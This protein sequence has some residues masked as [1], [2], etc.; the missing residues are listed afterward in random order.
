MPRRHHKKKFDSA[1]EIALLRGLNC[2]QNCF[3]CGMGD[4]NHVVMNFGT[5]V[6][7]RCAGILKELNYT[8]RGPEGVYVRKEIKLIGR[9]GNERAR[10]IWMGNFRANQDSLPNPQKNEEVRN[11]IIDKYNNKKYFLQEMEDELRKEEE[12]AKE[13]ESEEEEDEKDSIDENGTKENMEHKNMNSGKNEKIVENKTND[14]NMG[15]DILCGNENPIN[16]SE[17][18]NKKE[19]TSTLCGNIFEQSKEDSVIDTCTHNNN[20][21][22]D[23]PAMNINH[24]E[25]QRVNPNNTFPFDIINKGEEENEPQTEQN[26]FA[27]PI[28]KILSQSK[29]MTV[30]ERALNEPSSIQPEIIK[31]EKEK[32][33]V[34]KMNQDDFINHLR[35]AAQDRPDYMEMMNDQNNQDLLYQALMNM[36]NPNSVNENTEEFNPLDFLSNFHQ[37]RNKKENEPIVN[38]T[39]NQSKEVEVEPEIKEKPKDDTNPFDDGISSENNSMFQTQASIPFNRNINNTSQIQK[40]QNDILNQSDEPSIIKPCEQQSE[41]KIDSEQPSEFEINTDWPPQKKDPEINQ[42]K[43]DSIIN[44]D[45]PPKA[46]DESNSQINQSSISKVEPMTTPNMDIDVDTSIPPKMNTEENATI[47]DE[48]IKTEPSKNINQI[49]EYNPYN[50]L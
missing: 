39:T 13:E 28:E 34:H 10:K 42:S 44:T 6:C 19:N 15:L 29:P 8:V 23:K 21:T 47:V 26:S 17:I 14:S 18:S 25:R 37:N 38:N 41:M 3:D 35:N 40:P 49:G 45:W 46:K 1:K 24:P 9:R 27:V 32:P 31:V 11:H 5:F 2:N 20:K 12:A 48:P 4:A 30:L 16:Q 22:N 7:S 43:E 36:F 50:Y 33:N